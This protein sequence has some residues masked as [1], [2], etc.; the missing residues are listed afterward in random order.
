VADLTK[1]NGDGDTAAE[2]ADVDTI[3]SKAPDEVDA[4]SQ[5]PRDDESADRDRPT[6]RRH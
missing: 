3:D 2:R 6:P 4:A 1:E 5:R